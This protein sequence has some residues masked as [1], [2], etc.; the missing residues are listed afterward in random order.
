MK[1]SEFKILLKEVVKESLKEVLPQILKEISSGNNIPKT[2][3]K[4][5]S[6]PLNTI[7]NKP[8]SNI[9]ESLLQDT[10]NNMHPGDMKQF[11][12]D[13]NM[14]TN[15]LGNFNPIQFD[16]NELAQNEFDNVPDYSALM[17]VMKEKGQI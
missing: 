7:N 10:A 5:N 8:S 2:I 13:I 4:I 11:G 17:K 1:K 9:F 14:N 3:D 16:H 6:K 12:A 15:S